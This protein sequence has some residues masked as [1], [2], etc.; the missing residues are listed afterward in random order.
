[1][2]DKHPEIQLAS[3]WAVQRGFTVDEVSLALDTIKQVVH[4]GDFLTNP[5]TLENY[6]KVLSRAGLATRSRRAQWEMKGAKSLEQ[7]AQEKVREILAAEPRN[8]LDPHQQAE[9]K[10]IEEIALAAAA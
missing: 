4:S 1:M 7:S 5:H 2:A 3:F 6:R 9:L 10:R 8:Y